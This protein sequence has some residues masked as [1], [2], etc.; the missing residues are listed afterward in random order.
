VLELWADD[1][2]RLLSC[3]YVEF[4]FQMQ[5]RKLFQIQ[6]SFYAES[7]SS[8]YSHGVVENHMY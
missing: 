5:A 8:S 6:A 3:N 7:F 1:I 2:A 4:K